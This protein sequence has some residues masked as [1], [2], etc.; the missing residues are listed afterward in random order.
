MDCEFK[1]SYPSAASALK[2]VRNGARNLKNKAG[3]VRAY[4]CPICKKFHL[5]KGKKE[6]DKGKKR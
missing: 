1:K 5:T 3:R 4:L 6:K 2:M